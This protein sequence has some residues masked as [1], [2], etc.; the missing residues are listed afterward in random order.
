MSNLQIQ[1]WLG[2][3]GLTFGR[4]GPEACPWCGDRPGTCNPC[5]VIDE[6]GVCCHRC[7]KV[8][9]WAALLDDHPGITHLY[10]AARNLVHFPHQQFVLKDVR[11]ATPE[12]LLR[13]AWEFMLH[14]ANQDRLLFDAE[15]TWLSAIDLAASDRIDVIRSASGAWLSATTLEPRKVS[16]DRTLKELP[17]A[18]SRT[19]IDQALSSEPLPGFI[20][21]ET[22]A[23]S[24]VIAPGMRHIFFD[25]I[26][27]TTSTWRAPTSD[28]RFH[29][30]NPG[31]SRARLVR[32]SMCIARSKPRILDCHSNRGSLGPARDLYSSY[33]LFDRCSW[34]I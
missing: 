15:G 6:R 23:Y 29:T 8:A 18:M 10:T 34:N 24:Y 28:S 4:H 31:G 26:A 22:I 13:P 1:A 21:I 27:P 20:P 14:R 25:T 32:T 17:W 19:R 2:A 33:H 3:R 7:Q 11:P 12:E 30:A 16:A 5:V 9:P